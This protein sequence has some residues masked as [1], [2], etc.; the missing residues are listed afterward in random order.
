M[1]QFKEYKLVMGSEGGNKFTD[2]VNQLISDGWQ[3]IGGVNVVITHGQKTDN[4]EM[5]ARGLDMESKLL[6]FQSMVR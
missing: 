5:L 3:P 1:T 6:T 4:P 2:E